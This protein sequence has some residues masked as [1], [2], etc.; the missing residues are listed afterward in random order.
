MGVGLNGRQAGW[1]AGV[2]PDGRQRQMH[3]CDYKVNYFFRQHALPADE[4]AGGA[5]DKKRRFLTSSVVLV[6]LLLIDLAGASLN[7]VVMFCL[8]G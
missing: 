3:R 5:S 7:N 1:G 2:A 4:W 6:C 8:Q